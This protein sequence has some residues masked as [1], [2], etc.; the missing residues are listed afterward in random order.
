M[1]RKELGGLTTSHIH[2]E[3]NE[4]ILNNPNKCSY[5]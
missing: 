1:R 2:N 5:C 4:P 3:M